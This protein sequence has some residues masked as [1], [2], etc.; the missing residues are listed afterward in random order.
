MNKNSFLG[1]GDKG[2]KEDKG[3]GAMGR[4]PMYRRAIVETR[5]G[6]SLQLLTTNNQQS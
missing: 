3:D 4:Q 1:N 5:H 2:D 6:A